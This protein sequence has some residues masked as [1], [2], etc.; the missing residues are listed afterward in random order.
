[1][2]RYRNGQSNNQQRRKTVKKKV[3][4]QSQRIICADF[5]EGSAEIPDNSVEL[6]FSDFPPD[7]AAVPSYEAVAKI[8]ARILKPG[9]SL[10]TFVANHDLYKVLP[11]MSLHLTYKW[12][13]GSGDTNWYLDDQD[14]PAWHAHAWFAKGKWGGLKTPIEDFGAALDDGDRM[15]GNERVITGKAA[16]YFKYFTTANGL[17]VDFFDHDGATTVAAQ[18]LG[19]PSIAFERNPIEV[20]RAEERIAVAALLMDMLNEK[21]H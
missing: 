14:F 10:I 18:E 7:G 1:M 12:L 2:G 4:I 15:D 6:I 8:G 19:R 16:E 11:A 20:K 3:D 5:R 9:G 21:V 17:V 13:L